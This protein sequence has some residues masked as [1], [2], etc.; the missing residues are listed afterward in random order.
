MSNIKGR[1]IVMNVLAFTVGVLTL[2]S[3]AFTIGF[4]KLS[5]TRKPSNL[6][7]GGIVDLR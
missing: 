5:Q 7:E 2:T 3:L 4:I 1:G 6:F